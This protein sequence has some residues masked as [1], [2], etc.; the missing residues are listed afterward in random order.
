MDGI[1]QIAIVV[2]SVNMVTLGAVILNN[3]RIGKLEGSLKNG[4]FTTCPFYKGHINK[5]VK[6]GQQNGKSNKR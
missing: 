3:Y 6:A 5:E 4:G 1:V 2:G